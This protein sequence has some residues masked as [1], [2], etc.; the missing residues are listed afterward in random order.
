MS[1][2]A[3]FLGDD[4][5]GFEPGEVIAVTCYRGHIQQLE[6]LIPADVP[7]LA[8][9][10]HDVQL[11]LRGKLVRTLMS[12][13]CPAGSHSVDWNGRDDLGRRV[14]SG[15]YF[16]RLSAPGVSETRKMILVD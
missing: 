3:V 2:V 1:Q 15:V 5:Y 10:H 9:K 14:A 13:E 12:Q 11:D 6:R 7:A 16:C 4:V 8:Q